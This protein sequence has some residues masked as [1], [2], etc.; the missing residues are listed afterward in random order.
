MVTL[1][2]TLCIPFLIAAIAAL[3]GCAAGLN[4]AGSGPSAEPP[5]YRVG[6]RWV[7]H[8]E[9]GFRVKTVW[10]ETHEVMAIGADGIT[11]RIT[12]KG[13]SIDVTRTEIWSAPGLVKVGAVY[14]NETRRFAV[15]L[16]RYEFPLADGKVWNQRVDNYNEAT[17]ATG[18]LNRYVRV[19]GWG[20]V[21]TPAGT[22]DA[23]SMQVVMRLDDEEF[24]RWGTDC[25][26]AVWYAPA[27]RAMVKTDREAWYRE[28]GDSLDGMQQ[29]RT[30]HGTID[31]VSFTPGRS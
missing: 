30:Q 29:V 23:I 4:S 2:R 22:F 17:K 8:G 31:L 5:V 10:D 3:A 28:K 21:T 27:V 18:N 24:W 9:D 25:N 6:D 19:G 12:V 26:Y 11:V 14:D 15:P 13:P 16:Q 7:Y 1:P 20:K